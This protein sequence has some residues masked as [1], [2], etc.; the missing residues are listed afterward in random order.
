MAVR[1]FIDRAL[2]GV[3]QRCNALSCSMWLCF[4]DD[5]GFHEE[6]FAQ[7]MESW[8]AAAQLYEDFP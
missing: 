1:Q 3:A 6:D 7:S 2:G 4:G 8:R 5:I